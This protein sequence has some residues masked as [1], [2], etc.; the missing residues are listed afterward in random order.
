MIRSTPEDCADSQA[1]RLV[2]G[3]FCALLLAPAAP[4]L[5]QTA[6]SGNPTAAESSEPST[7]D[8]VTLDTVTVI[9]RKERGSTLGSVEPELT[10]DQDSIR[11]IGASDIAEL[12]DELTPLTTSGRSDGTPVV[13]LNGQ[14]IGSFREIRNYPPE[15]IEKIEILPEEA[16]LAYGYAANQRV[17]NIILRPFFHATTVEAEGEHP[18]EGAGDTTELKGGYLRIRRDERFSF[19]AKFKQVNPIYESDRD[20]LE[21]FDDYS[22][23]GNIVGATN[24]DEIDPDLSSLAGE[25]VTIA[26]VPGSAAT[27]APTLDD[28]LAGANAASTSSQQRY[29]MLQNK[30]RTLELDGSWHRPFSE[31]TNA[32]LSASL[33]LGDGAGALGLPELDLDLP[34]GNPYSPFSQDVQLL[35]YLDAQG[36]LRSASDSVDAQIGLDLNGMIRDWSWTFASS[37][38]HTRATK[39]ID[40]SVDASELQSWIDAGDANVNPFAAELDGWALATE[41]SRS[42]STTAA[43][44]WV[45]NGSPLKLPAG[46]VNTTLKLGY[47]DTESSSHTRGADENSDTDRSRQISSLQGNLDLPL[48]SEA[49]DL[50]FPGRLGAMLTFGAD[51]YSDFDTLDAWGWGLNWSPV[52]ALRL[53]ARWDTRE[54]AP[55]ISQLSDPVTTT[56]NR[57]VYDYLTGETV[58]VTRV[59]GGNPDLQASK[60]HVSGFG[61][62]LQ[63]FED[64]NLS[65]NADYSD[66]RTHHPI[67]SFST[68]T[69][70]LEAAYPDRFVRDDDGTLISFDSRPLNVVEQ[71][72]RQFM[73]GINYFV[74]FGVVE[75]PQPDERQIARREAERKS[76]EAPAPEQEPPPNTG[77]G[78][79]KRGAGGPPDAGAGGPGPGAGPGGPGGPGG[80]RGP[81]G[82]GGFRGPSSAGNLR[83]SLRHTIV[84]EDRLFLTPDS[85]PVDYLHGASAGGTGGKPRQKVDFRASLGYLSY[86]ARLSATWQSGTHVDAGANSRTGALDFSSLTTVDLRLHYDVGPFSP[87]GRSVPVIRGGRISFSVDNLFNEKMHVASADGTTPI[88]YQPDELDPVGRTLTLQLRK[89]FR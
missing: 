24:G 63:P 66:R 50:P 78:G 43:A 37:L 21:D 41:H 59:D 45:L 65:V 46:K 1:N 18:T 88:S 35:R 67:N 10:L 7:T 12:M 44:D 29:N 55:T 30:S 73:W 82:P 58:E 72:Q 54:G 14:R 53:R 34:A 32:T 11:S 31:R 76:G 23:T 13:L 9:A 39:D 19:N 84:L 61:L 75:R 81:G 42:S 87:L 79:S 85:D 51:Q 22:L 2:P 68:P 28:F 36:P 89:Q 20:L 27:G 83:L 15:A 56:P 69:A 25:E 64:I 26:A 48:I 70:E 40:R 80:G 38:N 33:D 3:L 62:Q 8:A 49:N 47:S 86:G 60:T 52:D 17:V 71:T 74:R 16:A 6:Q 4:S 77:A 5:A 57:R